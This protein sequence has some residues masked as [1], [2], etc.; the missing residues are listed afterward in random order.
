[1]STTPQLC[2]RKRIPTLSKHVSTNTRFEDQN[3]CFFFFFPFFFLAVVLFL[4]FFPSHLSV[5]R[6]HRNLVPKHPKFTT[7]FPT[8]T[9]SS[10]I[11]INQ[12]LHAHPTHTQNSS[13]LVSIVHTYTHTQTPRNKYRTSSKAL[14][15]NYPATRNL[16]SQPT[17][18]KIWTARSR[19]YHN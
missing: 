3:G 1:M 13:Q 12:M 8:P 9:L 7:Q 4:F 16:R 14:G 11:H 17:S 18:A 6:I 10:R 2:L 5:Q 19:L 15:P